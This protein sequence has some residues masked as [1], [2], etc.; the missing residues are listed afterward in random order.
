MLWGAIETW[1]QNCWKSTSICRFCIC[2]LICGLKYLTWRCL[3]RHLN[4]FRQGKINLILLL[5]G[6][7]LCSQLRCFPLSWP[8]SLKRPNRAGKASGVGN[9]CGRARAFSKSPLRVYGLVSQEMILL[10]ARTRSI[11][12]IGL[13]QFEPRMGPAEVTSPSWHRLLKKQRWIQ[14]DL[15]QMV[16]RSAHGDNQKIEVQMPHPAWAEAALLL[17]PRITFSPSRAS[18]KVL[19]SEWTSA[20]TNVQPLS[21]GVYLAASPNDVS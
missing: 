3:Q 12:M 2:C 6:G 13:Q 14:K 18:H 20:L 10:K 11:K 15:W 19:G 21:L 7:I 17:W 16:R 8:P 5:Y 1:N 9:G 4:S